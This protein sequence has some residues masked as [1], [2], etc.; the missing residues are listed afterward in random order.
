MAH[1][2]MTRILEEI[3]TAIEIEAPYSMITEY[4]GKFSG[5]YTAFFYASAITCDEL[6]FYTEINILIMREI[7]DYYLSH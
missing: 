6:D 1:Y 2:C 3:A 5:A 7:T 4:Y